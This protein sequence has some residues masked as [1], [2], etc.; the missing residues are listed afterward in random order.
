MPTFAAL[1]RLGRTS[2]PN[3][4]PRPR[5]RF[6][7]GNRRSTLKQGHSDLLA[8]QP[9]PRC[10]HMRHDTAA[11]SKQGYDVEMLM[12]KTLTRDRKPHPVWGEVFRVVIQTDGIFGKRSDKKPMAIKQAVPLPPALIQQ[13]QLVLQLQ[14]Q[15]LRKLVEVACLQLPT[16]HEALLK[17][18]PAPPAA[19]V[20][21]TSTKARRTRKARRA[22]N[23]RKARKARKT[24]KTRRTRKQA[25]GISMISRNAWNHK[26]VSIP[27]HHHDLGDC[28][29]SGLGQASSDKSCSRQRLSRYAS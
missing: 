14:F 7:V 25:R 9:F 11:G 26:R 12:A 2:R 20:A 21:A 4:P 8:H 16:K 3:V 6:R 27:A 19:A 22:R 23:T 1:L 24:R 18:R 5:L 29:A 17:A 15:L 13:S 28:V 10:Q